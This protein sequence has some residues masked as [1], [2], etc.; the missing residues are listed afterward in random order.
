MGRNRIL[1]VQKVDAASRKGDGLPARLPGCTNNL[2]FPDICERAEKK[3][4]IFSLL[5]HIYQEK[6]NLSKSRNNVTARRPCS[7]R[8]A[9]ILPGCM[10]LNRGP[11]ANQNR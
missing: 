4:P 6:Q 1:S 5:F 8:V 9:A 2:V 10:S 3:S 7:H 11:P